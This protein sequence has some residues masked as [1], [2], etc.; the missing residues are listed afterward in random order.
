MRREQHSLQR[1]PRSSRSCRARGEVKGTVLHSLTGQCRDHS[2]EGR[3][4]SP[5]LTPSLPVS[6]APVRNQDAMQRAGL[7]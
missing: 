3:R 5:C 4:K 6:T 2:E 7:A 1:L